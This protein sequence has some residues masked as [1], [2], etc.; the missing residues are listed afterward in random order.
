MAQQ[1]RPFTLIIVEDERTLRSMLIQALKLEGYRIYE[2]CD[3]GEAERIVSESNCPFD[4]LLTDVYLPEKSGQELYES[5]RALCPELKVLFISGYTG[6]MVMQ[7]G[8]LEKGTEFLHK[9]FSIATLKEKV[10][11]ILA[12]T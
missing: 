9:P 7:R 11:K 3:A 5:L 2:A 1:P 10:R 8:M 12:R 4:L 6:S